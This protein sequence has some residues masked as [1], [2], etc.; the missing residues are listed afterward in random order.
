MA[1]HKLKCS[2]LLRVGWQE[3]FLGLHMFKSQVNLKGVFRIDIRPF[4]N[5]F[6]Y[7]CE[8][9]MHNS[10]FMWAKNKTLRF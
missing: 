4:F 9:M 7:F 6:C 10:C 2:G 8:V 3:V 1:L 5:F